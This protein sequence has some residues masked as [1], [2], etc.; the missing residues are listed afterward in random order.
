M[1]PLRTALEKSA[2]S[3]PGTAAVLSPDGIMAPGLALAA[4]PVVAVGTAAAGTLAFGTFLVTE[5]GRAIL[6]EIKRRR[7]LKTPL[8]P[9]PSLRGAPTDAELTA[10]CLSRPRTLVVR[11]RIGSRL[12]DLAPVLDSSP[13]FG[14]SKSGARR[15]ESRAPGFKGYIADHRIPLNYGTLMRYK[16]LAARLRLLLQLDSRLPLEWLLPQPPPPV[17]IPPELLRQCTAARKRL[18]KLLRAH[19]NFDR[20]AKH[21][22]TA[23]GIPRLLAVRR[24]NPTLHRRPASKYPPL[25]IA[26]AWCINLEDTLVENTKR[27]FERFLRSTG[28]P[29]RLEALRDRALSWLASPDA[30]LPGD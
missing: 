13:R 17:S 30:C 26:A 9:T 8:P 12:A 19:R 3:A 21:V 16:R 15:I 2:P 29:P 20:L 11:L 18:Q 10:D 28:L 6:S 25:V 27:E 22:D 5:T 24:A 4:L 1:N 14:I 7:R 23:L